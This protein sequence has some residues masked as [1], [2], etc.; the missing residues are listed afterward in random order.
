MRRATEA[1]VEG[2]TVLRLLIIA[3]LL[4]GCKFCAAAPV[5]LEGARSR[6]TIT[7]EHPAILTSI[8][9][10][11]SGREFLAAD[12]PEAALFMVHL[13]GPD[14]RPVY[15]SGRGAGQVTVSRT[16]AGEVA[17]VCSDFD[18]VDVEVAVR[19]WGPDRQG[20]FHGRINVTNRTQLPVH[21]VDFPYLACRIPLDASAQDDHLFVPCSF[22]RVLSHLDQQ[23]GRGFDYPGQASM[24]CMG[25]YDDQAGL[26]VAAQDGQGHAK[27]FTFWTPRRGQPPVRT[28]MLLIAQQMGE[29]PGADY[30]SPYDVVF[31][32]FQGDWYDIAALYKPWAVRQQWVPPRLSQRTDVPQW[33]KEPYA[34]NGIWIKRTHLAKGQEE[35][36]VHPLSDV[37]RIAREYQQVVGLPL[38]T[39]VGG[40][41][42]HGTCMTPDLV[43]PAQGEATMRQVTDRMRRDGNRFFIFHPG[44]KWTLEHSTQDYDGREYF[45]REGRPFAVK[46]RDGS[47]WTKGESG[48]SFDG[49][50]ANLCISTPKVRETM[51]GV[52][53]RLADMGVDVAA[54]DQFI[55]GAHP[56]CYDP[57]HDHLPGRGKWIFEHTRDV[58]Q[59]TRRLAK[60]KNPDFALMNEWPSELYLKDLDILTQEYE[61]LASRRG[62]PGWDEPVPAMGYVYHEYSPS[63]CFT[64]LHKQPYWKWQPAVYQAVALVR[65]WVPYPY[66]PIEGPEACDERG[67]AM[68]ARCSQALATYAR[69]YCYFGEML[70]PP[71]LDAPVMTE[72]CWHQWLK[73]VMTIE[74]P[75]VL[76]SAWKAEDGSV[77]IVMVNVSPESQEFTLTVPDYVGGRTCAIEVLRDGNAERRHVGVKLPTSLKCEAGPDEILLVRIGPE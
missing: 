69:P 5:V 29:R 74:I 6:L 77:G 2:V 7:A 61:T 60:A 67:L 1:L 46:N 52:V 16:P 58:F 64:R 44:I 40:W 34:A 68:W 9:D 66:C 18:G 54:Y 17:V 31:G 41:E 49:K 27:A 24:Q 28:L 33:V 4:I 50:Y 35:V 15:A 38:V 26:Y 53:E 70:K 22:G 21:R 8:V 56:A 14:G 3:A 13:L 45:E 57:T 75:S 71:P 59:Q 10:R 23:G 19:L 12:D 36:E 51:A 72:K 47:V 73:E 65:G 55:G 25:L 42:K 11:A 39:F 62:R 63:F 48:K 20:L 43:P 37:P 30:V 76:H 32:T